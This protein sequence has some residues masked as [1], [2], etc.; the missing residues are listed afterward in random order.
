M[1]TLTFETQDDDE[2]VVL[3]LRAHFITNLPWILITLIFSLIP[4]LLAVT[5][6][7]S[8]LQSQI[9][10]NPTTIYSLLLIWY[11]FL[12]AYA[13]QNFLLWY[14]NV[15]LVT[16]EN[17][18]DM[19]F[20]QLLYRKIASAEL[21][22]IEDVTASMGGV[23]QSLFNYGNIQIQTAGAVVEFVFERVPNPA[24]VQKVIEET[25]EK[26]RHES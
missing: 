14:F 7:L 2:E 6:G 12:F 19:D 1:P 4:P 5:G 10:L 9:G 13:F 23:A 20:F 22:K 18:V 15:Y 26:A 25:V 17:V 3:L 24:Y 8:L 21:S 16:N 11:L